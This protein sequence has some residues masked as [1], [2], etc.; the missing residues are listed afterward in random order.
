MPI[1]NYKK[2]LWLTAAATASTSA[3]PASAEVYLSESQALGIILGDK[4]IV[5]REQKSLDEALRKK[6]ERA[7]NLQFPESAYTFFVAT[8]DGKPSKYAVVLNE[9]GKSEPITFMV[10]MSPEGKVT[11]VVIMEFR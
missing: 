8:Q 11:E 6:L 9:I 4:A 3:V 2:A 7:S 1:P 5:R 10:G